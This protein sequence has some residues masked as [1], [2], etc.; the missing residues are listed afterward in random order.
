MNLTLEQLLREFGEKSGVY[1]IQE[2]ASVFGIAKRSGG[3]VSEVIRITV[4]T[5]HT[6]VYLQEEISTQLSGKRMECN[7]MRLMPFFILWYIESSNHGYF[8]FL[9]HNITGICIMT[10]CL[11]VYLFAYVMG[12]K[13]MEQMLA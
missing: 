11:A 5:I 13:I 3:N 8:D 1:Q 7:I 12:E 10:G 4:E 9:Y 6:K 2:F